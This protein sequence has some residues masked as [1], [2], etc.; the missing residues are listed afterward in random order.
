VIGGGNGLQY[1]PYTRTYRGLE[2]R[3]GDFVVTTD[4]KGGVLGTSVAQTRRIGDLS[5]RPSVSPA[6]ARR[7]ATGVVDRGR[8]AGR[9]RLL[10]HAIGRPRLA[11]QVTVTGS[12]G[13]HTSIHDV[14]VDAR[15]G[16]RIEAVEVLHH[17]QG[18]GRYNGP[19]PLPL[20]T[21]LS[22]STYSLRDPSI[23][24]LSCQDA[25]TEVTF[26][27]SDDAWGN[28]GGTSRETGC[29]DALYAVQTEHD[30]LADWLGRNGFDGS[31]GGW[32]VRVGLNDINAYYCPPN[33]NIPE[34]DNQE[35]VQIGRNEAGE[36]ISSM[37]VVAHEFGHG[38]DQH[39]SGGISAGKTSEFVAD[40]FATLTEHYDNQSSTYDEP[41]YLIGEEADLAGD[42]PIRNMYNPSALGDPNCYSSPGS[43]SRRRAGS[44]TTRC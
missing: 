7:V 30:M 34:C 26:S 35:Q 6:R 20:D 3:G 38:I 32:V 1:A 25:A 13:E 33:L 14:Y 41:D 43:A 15:T 2:V 10:V 22:G 29:V 5:T 40:V 27:G 9:P 44:S 24:S 28:G 39:T 19:N 21:S 36:W 18:T 4:S 23:S 11:W 37:D 31:G 12:E 42:G 16:S 17:G 8:S